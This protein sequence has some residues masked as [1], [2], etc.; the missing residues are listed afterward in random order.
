MAAANSATWECQMCFDKANQQDP[1]FDNHDEITEKSEPN[2]KDQTTRPLRIVQWNAGG[3]TPKIDEL[4]TFVQKEKID[5]VLVQETWLR[6]KTPTPKIK[7][8]TAVR[9]DRQNAE[10]P[11]GGLLTYIREKLA[12]KPNGHCQQGA[13]EALSVS[14]QQSKRKWITINNIYIPRGEMDLSFIPMKN[15]TIHAGD[16]NGHSRLWD[17][18]QPDDTRGDEI[19]DWML[20]NDLVCK[21]DGSPTRVNRAT[22]GFSSPDCTFATKDLSEKIKWAAI[23]DNDLGSDH[24]PIVTELSCGEF[25]TIS[26]TPLRARW[27]RKDVDWK[28]Y[29]QEIEDVLPTTGSA[30]RSLTSRVAFFTHIMVE[31]GKKHVGKTKPG[32][33]KFAMNPRVKALVKIRNQHRKDVRNKRKEW[34][35]AAAEVRR[36][37]EEAKLEAWSE[38]VETLEDDSDTGKVWRLIKTLDG[39]PAG[40]APNEAISRKGR[41]ITTNKG[42]AD[43][44]AKHY[45]SVSDL[46]FSREER[47]E[48]REC[49]RRI[50]ALVD[51][52]N[53]SCQPFSDQELSRAL[54]SMRRK[55]APGLDDIPPAFLME[56]GPKG[57]VELLSL[58]N[59]SFRTAQVPQDW[60]NAMVI[61]LL[62]A[63]KPASELESFRPISL[64]SCI[65]KLLER[66]IN[67]RLYFLAE[68]G[69]W[70]TDQQAG[71]RKHRS[72]E[73]QVIRLVHHVSDR[74]QT[75]VDEKPQRTVMALFDYSK[76]YDRTWK[77]RLLLKLCNLGAPAQMIRWIR[78]FLQTRTAEV[79][80]NGTLS[81]RVRMK[82]GLPQGSVLS[83]ILFLLFINDLVKD[84]PEGVECSLFA[85]DAAVYCSDTSLDKA[86]ELLQEAVTAVENWSRDNKLDLNVSKSCTFFFSTCSAE[87]TWRPDITLLGKKMPFGD[88]PKEKNPKFLG[89]TLDR[90]L[91]FN[92]HVESVCER[93]TSRCK[94]LACLASR[95]WGW[96]KHS[97]RRV[98]TATQRSIMDYAAAAWQPFCTNSQMAKLEV[99][100]NKCLR[101]ISGHYVNTSLD[102]LHLET[103]IPTYSTHSKQLIATAYEKGM[104]LPDNHPRRAALDNDTEHRLVIRSSLREQGKDIVSTLPLQGKA[105]RP[106]PVTF[107]QPWST[108]APNWKVTSNQSIK[109]DIAAIKNAIESLDANVVVYTD[110]SC[111]GGTSNGGA[112]AVVTTGT[113]EEPVRVEVCQAKGDE[114]TSSYGEEERALR[115]GIEWTAMHPQPKV[116]FC[117]DSLSLLQAIDSLN[118]KTE[119]I[120]RDIESLDG[121]VDLMYVPGHKDVPGNELADQYAKEAAT[122]AGPFARQDISMDAAR[123]MIKRG[124]SDPPSAHPLISETYACYSEERDREA[125][126][127]R[128]Q[129]ALLAQLR[130]GHHKSLGYYQHFVDPLLSDKCERCK[131]P[132]A[133]DSTKHWLTECAATMAPRQKIF[134]TTEIGLQ[135]MGLRPDKVLR[136]AGETLK[137]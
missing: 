97:L 2:S 110:G 120:R 17:D 8:F 39:V 112:A 127:T 28:G 23:D 1:H 89:V 12:F 107:V 57:R 26:L 93:V 22:G 4:R 10:F 6:K 78:A 90:T 18:Q 118:P 96:R 85:D 114:H 130:A 132:A 29:R 59:E 135:E 69:E 36:A 21:N 9:G 20:S 131:D 41:I 126:A 94:M 80:V 74:F 32:R 87:A 54:K 48:I 104:R 68:K 15:S 24:V 52:D 113:A 47:A 27:K 25:R 43:L 13:V 40:S 77:E 70:F 34:I 65:V 79:C 60:R 72:C 14:I 46:S 53:E 67:N 30:E 44:F 45:A 33:T 64:T 117:T 124:I 122:W 76:A 7:E 115:L 84:L 123:S 51:E 55:G 137:C 92:D 108:N 95:T 37:R 98:F 105:R 100:Q 133:V 3:L 35:E 75:L 62:K 134:G 88:G 102:A 116:A 38:F 49:K 106:I 86:Q 121:Q 31:A 73:D 16:F 103:G 50:E 11:G 82:Q 58:L 91:S 136:L 63:G 119:D 42:K 61:P 71:F 99:A 56:L 128:N 83:P 109:H 81:K 111:A 66:L 125:T 101:L 19:V 129:G 5:V